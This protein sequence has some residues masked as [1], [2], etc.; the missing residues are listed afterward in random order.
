MA[1]PTGSQIKKTT[2]FSLAQQTWFVSTNLARTLDVFAQFR[3]GKRIY[4]A[5]VMCLIPLRTHL[6]VADAPTKSLPGP[7]LTQHREVMLGHIP[8]SARL[9]H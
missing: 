4:A 5:G 3:T 7:V 8:F 2:P 1:H 6:M 9:L